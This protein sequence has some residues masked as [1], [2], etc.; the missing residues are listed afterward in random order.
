MTTSIKTCFKCS[1]EKNLTEF[2]RHPQ[3]GDGHV[4]KCKQCAR[5]DTIR[6]RSD[7]LEYY[8]NYDKHRAMQPHRVAARYQYQQTCAGKES[9]KKSKLKWASRNPIK[10]SANTAV[11]NAVRDGKIKKSSEC[12]ACKSDSSRLHGHHDDYSMPLLVRWLCARC[13]TAWHRENGEGKNGKAA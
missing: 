4:N 2:Y 11:G 6:N 12:D 5:A 9:V 1:E 10:R 13:H 3:M 7:R 8:T